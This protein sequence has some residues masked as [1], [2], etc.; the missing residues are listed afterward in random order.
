MQA[1][2]CL[3][4]QT[5]HAPAPNNGLCECRQLLGME[6]AHCSPPQR[7]SAFLRASLGEEEEGLV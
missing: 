1:H 7:P 5:I 6:K 3:H 4:R 2:T